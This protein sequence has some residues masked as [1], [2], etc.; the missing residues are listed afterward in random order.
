MFL[1]F[2]QEEC[3]DSQKYKKS[4]LYFLFVETQL[5]IIERLHRT[6]KLF[7]KSHFRIEIDRIS[8]LQIE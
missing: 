2:Q 7:E 5:H 6:K 8:C 1:F 3:C 4:L